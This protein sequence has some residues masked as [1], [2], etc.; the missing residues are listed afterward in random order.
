MIV[1]R[2]YD[3]LVE[4]EAVVVVMVVMMMAVYD[5]HDLRLRRIR[6]CEAEDKNDSKQNLFHDSVWRAALQFA[7][8]L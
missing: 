5:H 7:E 6:H 4:L 2:L 1:D 8:L 3:L